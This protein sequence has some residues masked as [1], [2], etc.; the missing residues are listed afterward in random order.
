[1]VFGQGTGYSPNKGD[2]VRIRQLIQKLSKKDLP[3]KVPYT[4]ATTD[5]DLGVFSLTAHNL[6]ANNAVIV[7]DTLTLTSGSI[8]DSSKN[9]TFDLNN[10]NDVGSIAF[11]T[12]VGAPTLGKGELDWS[13]EDRTLNL[14]LGGDVT[15]QIGQESY[16]RVLNNTGGPLSNGTVIFIDSA[17]DGIPTVEKALAIENDVALKTIGILT[18]DI[19]SGGTGFATTFGKVHDVDTSLYALGDVMYLSD[20]TPGAYT[21]LRPTQGSYVVSLG[22]VTRVGALDGEIDVTYVNV[23]SPD[24]IMNATG[25]PR[26]NDLPKEDVYDFDNILRRFTIE[27]NTA[28]G[29]EYYYVWQ[30]GVKYLKYTE[31]FLDIPDVTGMYYFYFDFGVLTYDYNPS[32]AEVRDII[33]NRV[34]LAQ[35]YWN[36]T[37]QEQVYFG[38][39]RHGDVMA[40][41]THSYLHFSRGSVWITGLS[42]GDFI[43]DGAGNIDADAQFSMEDGISADEDL[44]NISDG[45]PS[46]E[47]LPI[48]WLIGADREVFLTLNPGFSVLTDIDAGVG[49]TGRLVYN[50]FDG[51]DWTLATVPNTN[52]VLCHVYATNDKT[53]PTVAIIGQDTYPNKPAAQA[54]ALTEISNIQGNLF[55]EE[56]FPIATVIFQTKDGMTNSVKAAVVST[57]TGSDYINWLGSELS[58]GAAPADH[59]NLTGLA[60]DDHPQY[61]LLEG[62]GG[63]TITDN[64]VIEG[65]T[66]IEQLV[67]K[68]ADIQTNTNGAIQIQDDLGAEL[69][70]VRTLADSNVFIGSTNA[71]VL[72]TGSND[73]GIGKSALASNTTGSNNI[74]V[75]TL[76]LLVNTTGYDNVC[77]GTNTLRSSIDG[78]GNMAIGTRAIFN[79]TTGDFNSGI[80][81]ETL[82]NNISGGSNSAIGTQALYGNTIGSNN[83]GIG[84]SAG[85]SN[86]EGPNNTTV[87]YFAGAN[88]TGKDNTII[89]AFAGR[90]SGSYTMDA[91]VFI[92]YRAGYFETR[93]STL[94]IANS[95]TTTPLIYG[96]FDTPFVKINAPTDIDNVLTVI[97][98]TDTEHLI[99]KAATG[100][101]L[102][103]PSIE[104][105]NSSGTCLLSIFSDN[106]F[107]AYIGCGA[108]GLGTS[109][110]FGNIAYGS[111]T[112]FSN[113]SGGLNSAIGFSCLFNNTTG[114]LNTALGALSLNSTNTGGGNTAI[115]GRSLYSNTTGS[116]NIAIGNSAGDF[117]DGSNNVFIGAESGANTGAYS[118][119]NNVFIGYR[120]GFFETNSDKLYIANSDTTTPLVYGEFDNAILRIYGDLQLEDDNKIQFGT[121]QDAEIYYDGSDLIIEPDVVGTGEVHIAGTIQAEDYKSADGSLGATG[122][123]TTADAKTVTV[124]NGLITAIV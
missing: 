55:N 6:I 44:V 42:L 90:G 116:D 122:S 49:I 109:T 74:G 78:I 53:R 25:F 33:L 59:G 28:E 79:N 21:D 101:T 68:L 107:N 86:D 85:S 76:A 99:V 51:V 106:T 12:T 66:D 8:S 34:S 17:I 7:G 3:N 57:D 61:L 40:A 77:V 15:L 23:L 111:N 73:I 69:M 121:G 50:Y 35:I 39:E 87:G 124:K 113:T 38:D 65:Q 117:C 16:K 45:H 102:A 11:D 5:V 10:L 29:F 82:Y 95:D 112:L 103:H 36:S 105:Q 88:F 52:F 14:G 80:G 119:D 104:L 41:D 84:R 98:K 13:N 2:D 75:G 89:G 47:G 24:D 32:N 43:V 19:G 97:G 67:V 120:A 110:G 20:I 94:Y 118:A 72:T 71:G 60:D 46:T 70:T 91:S 9:I 56:I 115:G 114:G 1:M 22:S 31:D 100:Q 18:E 54:G 83:T 58:I 27:P 123:F 93:N 63:Q 62:R 108:V 48:S 4:G 96:E 81:T 64:I 30:K 37:Q 26:Q 92:G